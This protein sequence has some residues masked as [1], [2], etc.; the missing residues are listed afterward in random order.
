MDAHALSLIELSLARRSRYFCDN[1][2]I[3]EI[4]AVNVQF[5]K[6]LITSD[7]ESGSILQCRQIS[8]QFHTVREIFGSTQNSL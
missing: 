4:R 5:S 6:N 7:G 1:I 3:R 8:P 2:S